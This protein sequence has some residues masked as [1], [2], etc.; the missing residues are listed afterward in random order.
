MPGRTTTNAASARDRLAWLALVLATSASSLGCGE[1][2]VSET[3]HLRLDCSI[4]SEIAARTGQCGL[5]NASTTVANYE[6]TCL[7]GASHLCGSDA[8]DFL[9]GAETCLAEAACSTFSNCYVPLAESFE[10]RANCVA[11]CIAE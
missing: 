8:E 6:A 3:E 4:C 7:N 1:G 10:N 9:S 2:F 5:L 11:T